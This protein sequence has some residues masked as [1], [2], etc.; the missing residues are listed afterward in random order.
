MSTL[1]TR[2]KKTT[3]QEF[4]LELL[5]ASTVAHILHLQT[6]SHA[7]HMAMDEVYKKLPKLV[8][9]L[10]E[11]Y[12]GL[13]SIVVVGYPAKFDVHGDSLEFLD[14]M[15]KCIQADRMV[16]GP[17]S[18]IQN[19]IDEIVELLGSAAYKVRTLK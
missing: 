10:I 1:I 7:I 12:Q 8:D 5:H 19:I 15:L 18:A 14:K 13:N 9:D 17:E 4:F 6:R 16:A 3:V 2:A 11:L